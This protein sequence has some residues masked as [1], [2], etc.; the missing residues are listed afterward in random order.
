MSTTTDVYTHAAGNTAGRKDPSFIFL[1]AGVGCLVAA[2]LYMLLV[3]NA[4]DPSRAFAGWILGASF[5][6]SIQVG[7]LFMLMIW[8]AFDAGWSVVVRRQIE[9]ALS[10]IFWLG[11]VFLPLVLIALFMSDSG[12]VSWI[13]MDPG[14]TSPSGHGD[15]GSDVLLLAKAAYL[16]T[17]GFA[18]R[19]LVI[20]GV[21][22]GLAYLFRSWS[23]RMDETGDHKY[24]H[25]SRK[26]AAAGLV[27]C[28]LATTLG[29]IDWFKSLNYHWFSTMYGVWFFSASMRAGLS[30][31]V[32][33]CFWQGG[34]KE[35][36]QNIIKPSHLYLV[37]CIML[38]FTVFWAYISFSQFFL[39]YNAN[40]P[41][42]TFWY[43]IR[44]L[45]PDGSRSSWYLFGQALVYL[46][47]FVPFLWLLWYKNKFGVRLQFI[48]WWILAFHLIDLI[49]NILPQKMG[50]PETGMTVDYT[51]RP[52]SV[53]PVDL[54]VLLGAGGVC[55]WAYLRSVKKYR[56]IPIRDPRIGE[57]LDAHE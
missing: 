32:L 44:I 18:V 17:G 28:A 16:N 43:N 36:L 3:D 50:A 1:L 8:W 11:L 40:I 22:S 33:L 55:A 14:A 21:W 29:A 34:R 13:W 35:G 51:V 39:I 20:F 49:Y 52:F 23:F 31:L 42:E 4:A 56:P 54:L 5:W 15:V 27:L 45:G 9:H 7:M 6:I 38:A 19:Y 25:R 41:E 48:A 24:I 10:G 30:A 12:K 2:L 57:S 37:A 46:H 47:F 53:N 26:L